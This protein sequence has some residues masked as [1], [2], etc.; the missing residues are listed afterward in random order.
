C[1]TQL[2]VVRQG[3]DDGK[4]FG[5]SHRSR[6]LALCRPSVLLVKKGWQG[7]PCLTRGRPVLLNSH[8]FDPGTDKG[9]FFSMAK[10]PVIVESPAKARTI[11]R[12]RGDALI[13]KSS[14]G[15]VRDLPVSGA[16]SRTITPAE[17]AKEAA[18]T[19]SLPAAEREAHK[20][21]KGWIQLVAR[22]GIDPESGW[23]ADYEILPGKEKVIDELKRLAE[24]ADRI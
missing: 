1:L 19:R 5:G 11:N 23:A 22:M 3:R 6:V 24:K 8:R 17:R 14:A 16:G 20:R 12:Y 7:R 10:S 13:A 9:S 21:R 15:H 2:P 4:L 18:Y